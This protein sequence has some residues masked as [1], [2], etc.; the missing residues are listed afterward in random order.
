VSEV[1]EKD[2]AEIENRLENYPPQARHDILRL[3]GELRRLGGNDESESVN[4]ITQLHDPVTGL[5][6]GGA[7]GVRF[8]M[9]RA[10][11]TRYK[12]LFAVMS[13]DVAFDGERSAGKP[14]SVGD[15]ELTIRHVAERL[16]SCVRETDTL[17]RIGDESFAVILE[18]LGQPDH[19]ERVQQIVRDALTAPVELGGKKVVPETRVDM[20]F[21]PS[22][23]HGE[24]K[25][26][27]N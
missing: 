20:D 10:R 19:A 27:Y 11:A 18:D 14:F 4:V 5:L 24:G 8:A 25:R 17:A 12:K 23:Q 9:A 15:R 6:N 7:Y 13:I 16:E 2:L 3:M 1:R 26:V 22:S 21:Y